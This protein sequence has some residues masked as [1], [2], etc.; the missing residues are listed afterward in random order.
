[1]K[2]DRKSKVDIPSELR[3]ALARN[4]AAKA[5][6]EKLPPSHRRQYAGYIGEAKQAETRRRRALKAVE[7]LR[8]ISPA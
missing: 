8:M 7:M 1:M 3:E 5:V 4:P 2:A 6:F